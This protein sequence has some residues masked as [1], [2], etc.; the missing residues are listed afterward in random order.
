M[1][2][3]PI[4]LVEDNP[5][6]E[7]LTLRAMRKAQVANVIT[8][9]RDGAEALD[10]LFARGPH[11][12]RDP[13]QAPAMVLLDLK[14]PKVTGLD[15]LQHIRSDPRTRLIPVVVLTTSNEDRDIIESYGRGANSFIRKPVDFTA[16]MSAVAQ[17]AGYWLGLNERVPGRVA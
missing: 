12:G 3:R 8:V 2:R 10:W 14:L 15:V 17:L 1:D 5:N 7:E 16:F 9:V 6:D 13:Q 4:L 11:G